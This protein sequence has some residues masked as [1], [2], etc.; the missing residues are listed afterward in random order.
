MQGKSRFELLSVQFWSELLYK[1]FFSYFAVDFVSAIDEEEW[2][3]AEGGC[4]CQCTMCNVVAD[5][6][7]RNLGSF[8]AYI[9]VHVCLA[10]RSPVSPIYCLL[11]P[12]HFEMYS[13]SL[14]LQSIFALILKFSELLLNFTSL[15]VW[16]TS[17]LFLC[18]KLLREL[19]I[20]LN[21]VVV[22]AID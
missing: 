5:I 11:H 7:F 18:P 4:S 10:L 12:P 16:R 19:K 15:Q 22:F 1:V 6:N 17:H 9:R 8:V 21:S 14:A 20:S 2:N 13:M 3:N